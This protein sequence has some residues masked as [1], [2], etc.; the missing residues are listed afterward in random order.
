M[1]ISGAKTFGVELSQ[2]MESQFKLYTELLLKYNQ[3]FNL[4]LDSLACCRYLPR[5]CS[6]ADVGSGA[7]F[8]GLAVKI[9]RDD[10]SL[11][12]LDSLNKRVNFMKTVANKLN[13]ENVKAFHIRAEDAGKAADMREQFYVVTAR[14]VASMRV[15]AEYCLP[16]V[17]V[18]GVMLAMKGRDCWS[19]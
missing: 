13:L 12:L 4:N 2:K 19:F 11:T 3:K 14:A 17:K 16:L 15:L 6:L 7:G 9:A 1:L 10:V 18:G 8:P 5:G